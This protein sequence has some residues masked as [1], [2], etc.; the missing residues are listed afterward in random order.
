MKIGALLAAKRKK[1]AHIC[2]ICGVEFIGYVNALTCS[3]KCRS[4]KRYIAKK[5][6]I[7]TL[8]DM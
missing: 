2:E 1:Y 4:K 3:D 8:A 7:D 5:N 6:K